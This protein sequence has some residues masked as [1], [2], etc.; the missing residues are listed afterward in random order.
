M[1]FNFISLNFILNYINK[2]FFYS[3]INNYLII[4]FIKIFIYI[5]YAFNKRVNFYININLIFLI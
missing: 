5:F 2:R 1:L 4:S 3:N